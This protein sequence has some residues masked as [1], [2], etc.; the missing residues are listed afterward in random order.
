MNML[1]I[2]GSPHIHDN[3]NVQKMMWNVVLALLPALFV[4]VMFFGISSLIVTAVSVVSCVVVEYLITKFLLKKPNTIS[5]GS[6]VIT[7]I[8]LAFNVPSSLPLW[9]VVIGAVVAIGIAKMSFGGLGNNPFNPALVGRVFLLISFPADMTTFPA[10]TNQFFS[11]A[12]AYSGAT[13]LTLVK[14]GLKAGKTM[15]AIMQEMPGYMQFLVGERAG[16]LGEM[17]V[18]A[19]ILGG[20]YLLIRKVITWH[21]PFSYIFTVFCFTGILWLI[22]PDLY[23][24]PLFH[25]L[26]GGLFLGA[27]F[28]ATDLVTTPMSN[29]G[30]LIF[31]IGCGVITVLIRV[32]GAYPDGVSFAILIMNAFTPLINRGFK[33]KRFGKVKKVKIKS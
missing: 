10:P 26:T 3:Q 13:S 5:D 2:S 31:G 12:D 17:S 19:L 23:I 27:I 11:A 9:Q 16:S 18:I 30:K 25:I 22:N 4:A 7:G 15:E 24:N 28:M 14:E 20:L 1:T 6:A 21:I 32:W 8:L 29:T 33:P